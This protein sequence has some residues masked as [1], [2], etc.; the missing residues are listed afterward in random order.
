MASTIIAGPK[1]NHLLGILPDEDY[2]K[3]LPHL[4]LVQLASG[5]TVYESGSK[6]GYVYFPTTSIVSLL[7]IMKNGSS[8]EFA[9]I[10]NDGAVGVTLLLGA[11][12]RPNWAIVHSAGYAY[13]IRIDIIRRAFDH[14]GPLS[15]LLLR[16]LQAL[17]TQAGQTAVCNRHHTVEQQL[18]RWLLLS[19][20]RLSSN[21]LVVTQEQIAHMMGVRREGITEAAGHLQKAGSIHYSRGHI[22]V[23]DRKKL[24]VQ[25]CECYEVVRNDYD[26][27]FPQT[28]ISEVPDQFVIPT[29]SPRRLRVASSLHVR[30]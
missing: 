10:G 13:R 28:S 14:G 24:E 4:E 18:C 1:Q 16:Y 8:A 30:H 23:L 15:R 22:N 9:I 7:C 25:V 5:M 6:L 3:L 19:L 20:D 27:L 2:I 17:F 29:V 26:L 11:E 21:E 12:P